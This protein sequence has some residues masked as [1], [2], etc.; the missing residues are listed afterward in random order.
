MLKFED[1]VSY[2]VLICIRTT[3]Y[4]T[5]ERQKKQCMMICVA[6]VRDISHSHTLILSRIRVCLECAC[7]PKQDMTDYVKCN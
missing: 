4:A 7:L 6:K 3:V 2:D 1:Q 5:Q